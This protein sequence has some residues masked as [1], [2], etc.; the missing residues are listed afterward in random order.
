MPVVFIACVVA[1]VLSGLAAVTLALIDRVR[2]GHFTTL[3][4]CVLCLALL[5]FVVVGLAVLL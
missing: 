1:S 3:T 4:E 2:R 5:F